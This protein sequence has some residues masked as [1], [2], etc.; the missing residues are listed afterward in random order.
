M[1]GSGAKWKGFWQE[2]ATRKRQ[3]APRKSSSETNPWEDE[4][5]RGVYAV[6]D[7]WAEEHGHDL[8]RIYADVKLRE[9]GSRLRCADTPPLARA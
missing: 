3:Y 8:D 2:M 1:F 4:V 5:L 6:R 9:S 7:A